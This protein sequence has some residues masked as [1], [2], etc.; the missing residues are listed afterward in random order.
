V[1]AALAALV[2]G[3]SA[4][5]AR[6]AVLAAD[7]SGTPLAREAISLCTQAS[8]AAAEKQR[9][10]LERG[11]ATAE[12]A[13]AA[14]EADPKAHFA[15]FCNL[16]R[17]LESEG[18]GLSSV[19]QIERLKQEIDRSLALAPDFVDALA[20]KGAMLV[21]LPRLMGGDAEEGERLIRRAVELAPEH[22]AARLELA[23]A[24]AEKGDEKEALREARG[25]VQLAQRHQSE[26]ELRAARELEAELGS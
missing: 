16:G 24:L 5:V 3:P 22:P 21:R 4:G 8:E 6:A 12:R 2:F 9:T 14:A 18:A 17:K 1:T 10:L 23:K 19:K 20:G 25:V 13:V 26:A 15:V 7:A 11:L